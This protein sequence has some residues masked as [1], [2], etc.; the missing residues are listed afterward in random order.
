VSGPNTQHLREPAVDYVAALSL[1]TL[2]IPVP[3]GR[4]IPLDLDALFVFSVGGLFGAFTGNVG[5]LDG[6]GTGFARLAI[7]A[8][9]GL[10]GQTIFAAF[11]TLDP[12]RPGG[13]GTISTATA[14]RFE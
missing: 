4:T 11:V 2:G 8:A 5:T 14:I 10:A 6:S 1:G 12:R 13:L 9:Q 7:P 3:G